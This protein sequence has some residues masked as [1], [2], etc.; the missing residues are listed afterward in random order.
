[1]TANTSRISSGGVATVLK[2]D[3]SDGCTTLF[4]FFKKPLN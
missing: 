2:L 3:G 1:M 4:F